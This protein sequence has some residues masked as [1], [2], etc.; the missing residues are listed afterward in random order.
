MLCTAPDTKGLALEVRAEG[1]HFYVKG[2]VDYGLEDKVVD[3]VKHVPGVNKVTSD[4]YS[5]P[6]EAF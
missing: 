4:L 5:V 3:L 6:P 1:G 2:R